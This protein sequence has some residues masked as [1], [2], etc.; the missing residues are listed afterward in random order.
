MATDPRRI[1]AGS[2]RNAAAL[3]IL[4]LSGFL[5]QVSF[6]QAQTTAPPPPDPPK[7]AV[8][9]FDVSG[10]FSF[11]Q[12]KGED[13]GSRD[14]FRE[15]AFSLFLDKA[16]SKWRFHTEFNSEKSPHFDNDG[17]LFGPDSIKAH[18]HTAWANFQQSDAFQVRA[19]FLFVPTYWRTHRYQSTTLTVADPLIDRRIFPSGV[20]GAMGHGNKL[21]DD[22]GF[23]YTVYG[24]VTPRAPVPEIPKVGGEGEGGDGEEDHHTT[25]AQEFEAGRARSVGGTFLAHV[26]NGH[27]INVLDLGFQYLYQAYSN[28]LGARIY[29]F[30]TRIEKGRGALLGEFAHSSILEESGE[31][32]YMKQGL[33]VQPS[34]RVLRNLFGVYRYDVLNLD[35]RN[36]ERGTLTRHTA[37]VTWRPIANL[38]LKA[39]YN[40][41]EFT[42]GDHPTYSGASAGVVY[43]FLFR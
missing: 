26:P 25:T 14:A 11:R 1:R 27:N 29:G 2:R 9:P 13:P 28:H 8:L 7:K 4:A 21:F 40:R 12:L 15:Y 10:Y 34:Y 17:I 22:G 39:E 31:R 41:F 36:T 24:G 5:L 43:Y 19:G 32:L 37:G 38:S 33:Y 42:R 18:L 23:G 3:P 35:S 20:V 16:I 6:L 30:E